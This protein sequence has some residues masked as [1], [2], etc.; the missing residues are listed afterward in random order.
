MFKADKAL[1]KRI[2]NDMYV[3]FYISGAYR[4]VCIVICEIFEKDF[5]KL[6][7]LS[8]FSGAVS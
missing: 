5:R 3:G 1:N 4:S 6:K 7:Y 8:L 2:A